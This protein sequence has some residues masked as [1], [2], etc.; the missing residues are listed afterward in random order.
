MFANPIR[1]G[2]YR[3]RCG[4]VTHIVSGRNGADAI[5]TLLQVLL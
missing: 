4:G 5:C 2:L 1:P 3:V